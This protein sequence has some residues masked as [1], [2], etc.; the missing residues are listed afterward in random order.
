MAKLKLFWTE[1]AI[2]QRHSIFNY[3]NKRTHNSS[4]SKKLKSKIKEK[5]ELLKSNPFIGK[6]VGFEEIRCL[7]MDNFSLFYILNQDNIF[8]LSFWDNRQNPK[9]LLLILK[10]RSE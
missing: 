1:A 3:W 6:E 2:V 5:T 4:Y 10:K 9:S 7:P 8:I